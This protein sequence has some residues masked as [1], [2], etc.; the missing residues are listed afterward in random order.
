MM[1]NFALFEEKEAKCINSPIEYK[2]VL[3][4]RIQAYRHISAEEY[5]KEKLGKYKLFAEII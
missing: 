4:Q 3:N 5:L 1:A 2:D